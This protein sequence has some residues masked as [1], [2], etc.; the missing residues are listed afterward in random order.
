VIT[1]FGNRR[2]FRGVVHAS[3]WLTLAAARW[4]YPDM[5]LPSASEMLA[6][7]RARAKE[8]GP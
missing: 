3:V 8:R 6:R 4:A 1:L 2:P 7:A 5:K